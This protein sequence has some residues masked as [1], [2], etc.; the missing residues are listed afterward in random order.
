M[1]TVTQRPDAYLYENNPPEY[2]E[3][4]YYYSRW[5]AAHLPLVYKISNT[6][7]PT[8]SEDTIDSYTEVLNRNGFARFNLAG[9]AYENYIV[10]EKV[11]VTGSVY[12]G[13]YEVKEVVAGE[14]ITLNISYSETST[15]AIQRYYEN[16]SVLVKLYAGI[17]PEHPLQATDP[18]SYVG[19]FAIAPNLSNVSIIDVADLVKQKI[20]QNNDIN[21]TGR[22]NDLN[23]WTSFYIEYAETYDT[24]AS[25][26]P[27]TYVSGYTTDILDTCT[28]TTIANG[29]FTSNLDGWSQI[30]SAIGSVYSTAWAWNSGTA[31][32]TPSSPNLGNW[33][34][35]LYQELNFI[36]SKSYTINLKYL[37]SLSS[38]LRYEC[39]I[40]LFASD[41]L[42][43]TPP[44][45]VIYSAGYVTN[46]NEDVNITFTLNEPKK[47][48]IIYFQ[49]PLSSSSYYAEVSSISIVE[50]VSEDCKAYI[51]A[52]NGTRQFYDG[53]TRQ[54]TTYGGNMAEYVMNY[55]TQQILGKFLTRF[56]TPLLFPNNYFDI[57]CIIP[58]TTIDIP[59]T[60]DGL[61]YRLNRYDES[62]ELIDTLDTEIE[63][64]GDGVYRLRIDDKIGSSLSVSL[65]L[66]RNQTNTDW[67]SVYGIGTAFYFIGSFDTY[68]SFALTANYNV[69]KVFVTDYGK[70]VIL[71]LNP[72]SNR[73]E[74]YTYIDG[75][76][77]NYLGGD[78][79]FVGN[80]LYALDTD[81]WVVANNGASG[82]I[83]TCID[84]NVNIEPMG[85]T[86][87]VQGVVMS[88][89]GT[90][91]IIAQAPFGDTEIYKRVSNGVW[92]LEYTFSTTALNIISDASIKIDIHEDILYIPYH[93]MG[94]IQV[95]KY[96]LA[97]GQGQAIDVIAGTNENSISV[98][99]EN[100]IAVCTTANLYIYNGTSFVQDSGINTIMSSNS[101]STNI[102]TIKIESEDVIRVVTGERIYTRVNGT[103]STGGGGSYSAPNN[104]TTISGKE[105]SEVVELKVS[106]QKTIEINQECAKQSIYLSWINS[107]G[108]WEHFLFTARKSYEKKT[109]NTVTVRRNILANFPNDFTS[110]TQDD[111]IRIDSNDI[112][113]VRSQFV[114]KDRLD[115]IS[116]I[117]SSIRVQAWISTTE[118]I[119]VIVDTDSIKKY[120][121]GDKL[122][123]IEFDIIYP[124]ILGQRQ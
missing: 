65:Q 78:V 97:T 121:D 13:I 76:S 109:D 48:L 115:V 89:N 38:V 51:F 59:F 60:E 44:N 25:A 95:L 68:T 103:W 67:F 18:M 99:D 114:T 91:Y 22:P 90:I 70:A 56:E 86:P 79:S 105:L 53:L 52:E 66:V 93:F 71:A 45:D 69:E 120:S 77:T 75:T 2:G 61:I 17:P 15:G 83:L 20:N 34:K 123:A 8:N 46:A 108:N 73:S 84:A 104:F 55:N 9:S 54:R 74:V 39:S 26:Y 32:V 94:Q 124:Q 107:L 10:G 29:E 64:N 37:I 122:Y 11:K 36:A 1:L 30:N 118:K 24:Y 6:K 102:N 113:T 82:N 106:E 72:F 62:G 58:Q 12:S 85:I 63:N 5:S 50:D 14:Y 4:P 110:E 81:N 28:T 31:R 43:V 41:S 21:G 87:Y 19:T 49:F 42:A 100:N 3:D 92:V 47:Y 112:V 111:K 116:E 33:S 23:A 57:S 27:E 7:F 96:P 117:I 98:L 35:Y 119:T 88:S 40:K 80:Y 16:Y 101:D